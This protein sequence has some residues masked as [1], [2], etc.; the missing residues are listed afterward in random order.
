[1]VIA[2]V[3]IEYRLAIRLVWSTWLLISMIRY[4]WFLAELAIWYRSNSGS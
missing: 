3:E 2:L 1:M 4:T